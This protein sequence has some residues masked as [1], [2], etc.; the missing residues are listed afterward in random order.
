VE[1]LVAEFASQIEEHMSKV[2][3]V[4][5]SNHWRTNPAIFSGWRIAVF[6]KG[7]TPSPTVINGYSYSSLQCSISD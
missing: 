2:T 7:A 3:L 5:Q 1:D 4:I 6:R